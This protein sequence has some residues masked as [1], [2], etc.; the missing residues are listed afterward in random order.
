MTSSTPPQAPLVPPGPTRHIPTPSRRHIDR[1]KLD[2]AFN[3]AIAGVPDGGANQI[4][5]HANALA[6]L[7][8][9]SVH[10]AIIASLS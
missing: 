1:A 9:R 3:A 8:L 2:A 4:I 5:A 10:H 6:R 7:T